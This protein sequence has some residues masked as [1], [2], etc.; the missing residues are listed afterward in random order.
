MI[1]P[2]PEKAQLLERQDHLFMYSTV[3]YSSYAWSAV[4]SGMMRAMMR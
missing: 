1:L 2:T 4:R 3:G